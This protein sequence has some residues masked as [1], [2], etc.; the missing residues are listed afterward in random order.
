M[1]LVGQQFPRLTALV[2]HGDA[3]SELPLLWKLCS[4]IVDLGYSV[5][6]L[7]GTTQETA[8]NPGLEQILD[9]TCWR[10]NRQEAPQWS[11]V[12]SLSGLIS[13]SNFA[14]PAAHCL[15]A[16]GHAFTQDGI[17]LVY[18]NARLL[19]TLLAHSGVK[20]LLPISPSKTS[21]LTSY[22]ALKRLLRSGSIQPAVVNVV[23]S[24]QHSMASGSSVASNLTDCAKYFL[25]YDVNI[26]TI[27]LPQGE[28]PPGMDVQRAALA[29]VE[30]AIPLDTGWSAP[31]MQPM[32]QTGQQIA[33]S[34]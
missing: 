10:E 17:L 20:P 22:M 9:Y 6:V 18:S 25:D 4:A 16:L 29:M 7:D 11:V 2:S 13:L 3:Q 1:G 14:R 12:P 26:S 23:Q 30:C 24:A 21:L 27:F 32:I 28:A 31:M 8:D 5:T 15:S 19:S 33:R 34:H